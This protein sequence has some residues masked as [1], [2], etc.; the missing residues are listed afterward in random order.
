MRT[1]VDEYNLTKPKE[2]ERRKKLLNQIFQTE[3]DVRIEPPFHVDYGYNIHLGKKVY[4]NFNC[5]ILDVA[6]VYIGDKTMFAANVGLY[7]ATHPTDPELR[8][9]DKEYGKSIRVGKNCWIGGGVA[10]LPGVTIGDNSVI[11]T[12]SVV[13]HDIPPNCVA[14]GNPARVI[15]HLKPPTIPIESVL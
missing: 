6:Q 10:V 3:T 15:K 9:L 1:L 5:T 12:N 4:F 13:V 8:L 11:G 7:T 14:V 2:K